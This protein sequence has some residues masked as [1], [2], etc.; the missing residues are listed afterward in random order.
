MPVL[1]RNDHAVK[2]AAYAEICSAA[3]FGAV[4]PAGSR[5]PISGIEQNEHRRWVFE[6]MNRYKMSPNLRKHFYALCHH[7]WT[8]CKFWVLPE[9]R[10]CMFG[11]E[12]LYIPRE[13]ADDVERMTK[14]M[15]FV[16]K[17]KRNLYSEGDGW[18]RA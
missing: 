13:Y 14:M 15:D 12:G 10:V 6:V 8:H 2:K 18:I 3:G 5:G 4:T 17:R 16:A 1:T 7:K 9:G 11:G